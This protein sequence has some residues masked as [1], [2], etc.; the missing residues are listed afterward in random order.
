MGWHAPIA[1]CGTHG[2]ENARELVGEALGMAGS[3]PC[4]L[5]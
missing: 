3:S 5:P 4:H 1:G 2:N